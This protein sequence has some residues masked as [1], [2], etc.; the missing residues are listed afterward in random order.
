VIAEGVENEAQAAFLRN[1][2][3][4]EMQGYLFSRP[5]PAQGIEELLEARSQ[6]TPETDTPG[7]AAS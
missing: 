2:N 7:A 1:I 3:C 4:D 5:V 6:L